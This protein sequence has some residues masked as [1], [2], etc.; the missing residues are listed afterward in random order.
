MSAVESGD[1]G[2]LSLRQHE[3]TETGALAAPTVTQSTVTRQL[4][5]LPPSRLG[6]EVEAN[7]QQQTDPGQ[8]QKLKKLGCHRV[9]IVG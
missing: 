6:P 1:L 3:V 8:S 7:M 9:K 2:A 5:P 4:L